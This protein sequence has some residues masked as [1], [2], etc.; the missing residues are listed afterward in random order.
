MNRAYRIIWSAAR[1]AWIVASEKA[2]SGGRPPL[3]LKKTAGTILLLGVAGAAT[4][5]TYN[6]VQ[7]T[8]GNNLTLNNGDIS[9]SASIQS[10]ARLGINSGGKAFSTIINQF[11]AQDVQN[12][13]SAVSAAVM[14]MGT[15]FVYNGGMASQTTVSSNGQEYIMSGGTTSSTTVNS[16]GSQS[17]YGNATATLVNAG[18]RQ[19]VYKTGV[20]SGTILSAGG[21]QYVAGGGHTSATTVLSGGNQNVYSGGSASGTVINSGGRMFIDSGAVVTGL[22]Q[23][24]GAAL[25]I[26]A[27]AVTDGNNSLGHFSVSGGIATNVLLENGGNLFVS[28]GNSASDTV[29]NSRGIVNIYGSAT[30][31]IINNLGT[32]Y[33][34]NGGTTL[35]TTVNA[36][37]TDYVMTGGTAT[38][39]VIN[40]NGKQTVFGTATGTKLNSG[41]VQTINVGGVGNNTSI[42]NQTSQVIF[43]TAN[44]ASVL[45]GGSQYIYNGGTASQTVISGGGLM[46]IKSGGT[47]LNASFNSGGMLH[48]EDG[49]FAAGLTMASGSILSAGTGSTLSG[50]NSLGAFSISDGQAKNV[51]LENNG[52][53]VVGPA[54]SADGT[55][56]NNGGWE[57]VS[58]TATGTT[59][60]SG[61]LQSVMNGGSAISTLVNN[62]GTLSVLS[63]G[64][65]SLVTIKSGGRLSVSNG[66]AATDTTVASGG[67]LDI[68]DG[69]VLTLAGNSFSNNGITT[70]DTTTTASLDTKLTGSGQLTKNGTGLLTLGGTLSQ[71]QVNL[72]AGSLVMDG[73]QA[74]TNIIAQAGT[75]LSL[76]NSATLTGIIDPTDVNID[77]SST[78]N[79]T[80]DSLVDTLTNAGSIVFLPSQGAFT[81]HTLTATNLTGN[82]GTITLNTVAGDSSSPVDKVVIDGGRASGSTGLRILNRGGLGA[83]TTGNGIA[84]IQ[85]INGATTDSGAFSMTQPLAAGAY[86]YSL[87]RNADQSWYLTSQQVQQAQS[88]GNDSTPVVAGPVNYRDGMWSYAAMP[89]LSM[90]YDRLVAGSADTRFHY[91]PDSRVWGRVAAGQLRH[92]DSGSLTGGSVPESSSAYSFFQLGGDL[93]QL[94]GADADWRAGVFGATGLMRSDVW[95][96]GGSADAGTDRDTVY[97]GGA[98]VSGRSHAGL[99]ID[100]LLQASRHNLKAASNDDTRLSTHGKGWLA[101]AEV[102]QAFSVSPALAL[103]PQLQY[104]VQ[105]LS[106]NDGQDEA[107]SLSWSDS[108]RQSVRAGL[109]LGTAQDAKA[110]LAWWVTPSVTQSYGGHSGFTAS[111]PGVAGSEAS[112]RSNLSGTSVGLNGGVN[113][114]IRQNVTLGVQG[115]WSESLHGG[116]A[117]GYYGLVN[118]GVSFR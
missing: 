67:L 60:N 69:G 37:G 36:G 49:S 39:S 68:A 15:Q 101:S 103:E 74:F 22:T 2:G 114:R 9:N 38:S 27:N 57:V 44:S 110:T 33:V 54:G 19:D 21:N 96:D 90:D 1:Q 30:S 64:M 72:N 51:L 97:T 35:A 77:S 81:P 20:T 4:A 46:D 79:I 94:D 76:I 23:S 116:E 41:G 66:G 86:S 24:A 12:G 87:Y 48:A 111:A 71:S 95:R 115:G 88:A 6:N 56:I 3:A 31:S 83:Q 100:G 99:H 109:K 80:G 59:V 108:R 89:S 55:V 61:G 42:S 13:G 84:V 70:W 8:S 75:T 7:V 106:L 40:L 62:G 92:P 82:G 29:I 34:A 65:A 45:S 85:A 93:W 5:T 98:Y 118:L 50:L 18:G 16:G 113:A 102:G 26:N 17:V 63:G 11:A 73:L 91:A 107:A 28:A 14:S 53:L 105:G 43:G 58:G 117:G 25:N 112:F 78:W 10:N 52:K 47:A 32:L 104:T